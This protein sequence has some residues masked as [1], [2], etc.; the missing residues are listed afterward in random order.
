MWSRKNRSLHSTMFLLILAETEKI[1]GAI[2][3]TFHYVSINTGFC[4]PTTKTFVSLHSTMFLL[5]HKFPFLRCT[6]CS[7]F[8]FHYVSIN[9]KILEAF[10]GS[11]RNFTFHYV[12]INTRSSEPPI[13]SS[14]LYHILSTMIFFYLFI[15]FDITRFT[16]STILLM[17]FTFVDLS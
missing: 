12:S 11:M 14:I 8:T 3:F 15:Y 6:H 10:F 9:T 1:F 16:G 17:F 13:N 4:T 5:I 2:I 7:I